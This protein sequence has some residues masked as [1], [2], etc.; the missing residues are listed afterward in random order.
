MAEFII[1]KF[2]N[3][4]LSIDIQNLTSTI[5]DELLPFG[6]YRIN[7]KPDNYTRFID[8]CTELATWNLTSISNTTITLE[9]YYIYS[10]RKSFK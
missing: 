2:K 8:D 5:Y 4:S 7:N 6:V 9:S 1:E 10:G 3:P